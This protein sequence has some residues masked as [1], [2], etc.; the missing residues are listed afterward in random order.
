MQRGVARSAIVLAALTA[1]LAV[2]P[3]AAQVVD[4]SIAARIVVI[5]PPV[6][7]ETYPAVDYGRKS[8]PKD[9]RFATTSWRVVEETGNC[10]ENYLTSTSDGRLLDFGGRFVNYSDDRGLTWRSVRPL[11]PLANGEGAIVAAP[12]GDVLGVEWDP[13][14]G[15]HLQSYKFEA[16]TGQWLYTEMPLH[17]PFYDREWISVVPGPVTIDGETHEYVSFVKGGFP[18]KEPWFYS[19]DGLNYQAI[20]SKDAETVLSGA[21]VEGPLPTASDPLLDWAQPNTNGEMA[22][23]GGSGLLAGPDLLN[24]W[25]VYQGERDEWSTFTFPDGT[26]PEGIFQADSAGRIHNVVSRDNG[27]SFDYRISSDG[28]A[29]WKVTP[30]ELPDNHAIEEIDFRANLAAG[31]GAVAM[32]ASDFVND[33][34]QDLVYKFDITGPGARLV[35]LHEVG[36]GDVNSTGGFGNDVRMDFQS[37]TVFSDGR[38]AVTFLDSTTTM[39]HPVHGTEGPAPAIAVELGT[40]LGKRIPVEEEVPP[41][42]GEP[43]LAT[44]WDQDA[45]GWTSGGTGLWLRG[46]PGTKDG[47]DDPS[48][49]SFGLEGAQY[50]DNLNATLT[51]PAIPTDPGQA[52]LEFWMKH[53]LE[54]GFDFLWVEWSATGDSWI[55][56]AQVT[57]QNGGYPAWTKL[58]LGFDSPGGAV[59]V[60][61]RFTSDLLC[62]GIDPACGQLWQGARVDEVVVGKQAA[63]TTSGGSRRQR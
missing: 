53:D 6:S 24:R 47:S 8:G 36:L 17:Q 7:E 60:R 44:T 21:A 11:T 15:D 5:E 41:V 31:I 45:E 38:V 4:T 3:A 35:R 20:T 56:L 51:S 39:H 52:V 58:T 32:R 1:M 61:F 26:S 34:D 18:W 50:A 33:T 63:T 40:A 54:D 28:G 30:V 42:M 27:A 46:S 9:D 19:T 57:G 12:G 10:C 59:F 25:Y 22:A 49:A 23:L 29:T 16:D 62:S 13:Y 48:T 14:S 55:P 43:I 2:P 37:V